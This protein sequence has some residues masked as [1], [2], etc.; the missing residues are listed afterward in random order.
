MKKW[1]LVVLSGLLIGLSFPAIFFGVRLPPLGFL[2]WVGLVPLFILIRN[3]SPKEAFRY[4][5]V[6]A[7]I[8]FLL[9]TYWLFY[10]LNNYGHVAP[11]P[12]AATVLLLSLYLSLHPAFALFFARLFAIGFHKLFH[13][14]SQPPLTKWD[15]EQMVWLP[16]FWTIFEWGRNYLPVGG[17]PWSN[18][19]MTQTDFLPLIQ[20]ADITGAYGIMFL[21]VW[22]NAFLAEIF[23]HWRGEKVANLQSKIIVTAV[24]LLTTLSYGFYRLHTEQQKI[25]RAT[26]LNVGLIQPNIPQE[27]KW[28]DTKIAKQRAIF[29]E[30][31]ASLQNSVDLIIWPEASWIEPVPLD[32]TRMPPEEL[33]ITVHRGPVPFTLLGLDFYTIKN[34][35]ER[36]FNSAA[37]V[38]SYGN[39]LGKYN[40]VHLVPFGEY[41]PFGKFL[42]FIGPVATIGNFEAG[43]SLIPLSL[44]TWQIAPLICFEDVFPE[45]SRAMVK[46]GANL[47]INIS[48]DAWYGLSGAAHEHA[49]LSQLRAVETRRSVVRG[50]NTGLTTIIDST[51]KQVV[52]SPIFE[53]S[54]L[55]HQVALLTGLTLYTRLG[56]WFVLACFI[57]VVWHLVY[58]KYVLK[59]T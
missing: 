36:Y 23:L 46:N 8:Y 22:F 9:S 40:K 48:N 45:I 28:D 35:N 56:D 15:G 30:A 47:L 13:S 57:Y 6:T 54:D 14:A 32:A 31:A 39:I 52:S 38:N 27:E 12:S 7:L 10:A 24:L 55:V 58:R 53:R 44:E 16:I 25:A 5:Y 50:T 33:G 2:S 37:L 1:G 11:L 51:G 18:L 43:T 34:G 29:K 42:S 20:I 19:A 26:H 17:Y 3:A 41:V 4:G 21:V 59:R 49:T